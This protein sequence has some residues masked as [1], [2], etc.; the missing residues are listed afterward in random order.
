ML[1]NNLVIMLITHV[2][3]SKTGI[4]VSGEWPLV[5]RRKEPDDRVPLL[6]KDVGRVVDVQLVVA[7]NTT[8]SWR[9]RTDLKKIS[10]FYSK[11]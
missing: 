7:E 10:F 1:C 3:I 11:S 2:D 8:F 9:F 6:V 5:L 4:V